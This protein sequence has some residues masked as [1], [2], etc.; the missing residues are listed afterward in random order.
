MLRTLARGFR[1]EGFK[2]LVIL[3]EIHHAGDALSW[4]DAVREAFEP[5]TRRLMLTGTPFRSDTNPIPFVRYEPRATAALRSRFD[6]NYGYGQ[7]L[8]DGIV[9]P[10]LFMAYSGELQWRTSAGDEV[11]GPARGADDQGPDQ[12]RP[13]G[14]RS[15]RRG[16]GSPPCCQ[17]PTPG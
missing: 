5:A 15:T 3:D 17:P 2:T 9:R 8:A 7:A 1:V 14:P 16:P 4:G 11:V 6:Y 12:L 10:V 13:C